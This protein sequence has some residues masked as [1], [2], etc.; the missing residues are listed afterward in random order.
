MRKEG[1]NWIYS[2]TMYRSSSTGTGSFLAE[3]HRVAVLGLGRAPSPENLCIS[4][5]KNGEF[6]CIPGDIY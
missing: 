1:Y 5:I 2:S 4:Y 6:L 3:N